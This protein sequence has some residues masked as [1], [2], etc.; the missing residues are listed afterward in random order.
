MR[1]WALAGLLC[2]GVAHADPAASPAPSPSPS[3]SVAAQPDKPVMPG[4]RVAPPQPSPLRLYWSFPR[5]D[6]NAIDIDE[7]DLHQSTFD[8]EQAL[9]DAA[10]RCDVRKAGKH[11]RSRA[12][13]KEVREL[14]IEQVA[15]DGKVRSSSRCVLPLVVWRARIGDGL[16]TRLEDELDAHVAFLTPRKFPGGRPPRPDGSGGTLEPPPSQ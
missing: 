8:D 12:Q 1:G 13:S 3:P 14:R 2:A 7:A 16:V 10:G 5:D 11:V 15:A 4:D 6:R 9:V